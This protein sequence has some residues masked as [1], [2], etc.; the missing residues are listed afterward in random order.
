MNL[1]WHLNRLK[2]MS[3]AEVMKRFGEQL[4]ITYS[5]FQYG[6]P[7]EWPYGRFAEDGVS[8]EL[9]QMPGIRL[10][11]DPSRYQVY[12]SEHDLTKRLDWFT[13]DIPDS[14]WP[15]SHYAKIDYRPGN[16]CGDVRI[17][18]ELSR[19]QFLPPLALSHEDLARRI[20]M[21]WLTANPYL[22]GPGY[23][24]SMEVALRWFP[25]YWSACL[26]QQPLERQF[27][28]DL[29]GFAV[30]S[31]RFIESR[32]STH[33][34]AGNHLIVE[35]VGLF[36][37]GKALRKSRYGA[38]WVNKARS[39]LWEQIGRQIN[40]DGSNQ[41]QSFWYL[42][43][44]LD[45]LFH[46][47]LL[48]EQQTIPVTVKQRMQSAL[49]FVNE[50]TLLN[51][52]FPDYGDRDDGFVFRTR[53]AYE[54]SPFCGLLSLG[55]HFFQRAEWNRETAQARTRVS[56]WTGIGDD[57]PKSPLPE[58]VATEKSQPPSLKTYPEGGMT[59][60]RWGRG[61]VLFRHGPLGLPPTCG[62]GH[63]DALSVLFWWNN[64]PVLIDL[65]SGQYNGNQNIRNF[66][67]STIAHNT[68]EVGG[69]N[70]AKT[71][72][73]FMW[74]KSYK[75]H[76]VGVAETP[77]LHV[78]ASHDGYFDEMLVIHS[79]RVQWLTPETLEMVDSFKGATDFPVRGAFHL[80]ECQNVKV[81]G[82]RVNADFQGFELTLAMPMDFSIQIYHGSKQPFMGWR[83]TIYGRWEPI[84][85]VVFSGAA[86]SD[87]QYTTTLTIASH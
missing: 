44:V 13:S 30:A 39:I 82:N 36:W 18:W 50:M 72:G 62:H 26:F 4:R 34:S 32:L 81:A 71:L 20:L 70:Q 3:P 40:P 78:N 80:G 11:N 19:L 23:L 65:G 41:E 66:F 6:N 33:S 7:A 9:C 86:I 29:T 76:V 15:A 47:L 22:H 45:A 84:H 38:H 51:G 5:T 16:P 24:S 83:S 48:E 79:R 43:F 27:L 49:E 37:L 58:D 85:S 75:V 87:R 60:M 42:G 25:T 1:V 57:G 64:V 17:N 69:R 31:G 35:A 61:R 21:D 46:Y 52:S 67:R 77:L 63:A 8:L 68:V 12:S 56:F 73:P 55:A 10:D 54:E 59:L 28:R 74:D 14:R 53:A 2:K